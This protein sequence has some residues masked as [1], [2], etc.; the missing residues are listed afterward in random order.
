[1]DWCTDA[2][3]LIVDIQ[4]WHLDT[5]PESWHSLLGWETGCDC[6]SQ[7][8]VLLHPWVF[9]T[10]G[11]AGADADVAQLRCENSLSPYSLQHLK[12]TISFTGKLLLYNFAPQP[13]KQAHLSDFH[14]VSAL[15]CGIFYL[16]R[17][18]FLPNKHLNHHLSLKSTSQ[19]QLS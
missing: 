6:V 17:A 19:G 14:A 13:F 1:M 5:L 15:S 4:L 12:S 16:L 10:A 3:F 7:Q 9:P 18:R 2:V 8:A 11:G